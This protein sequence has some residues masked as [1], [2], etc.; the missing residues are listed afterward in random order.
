MNWKL[1]E[2]TVESATLALLE[3][4]GWAVKLGSVIAP[5]ML[6]ATHD[7]YRVMVPR[8]RFHNV[9]SLKFINGKVRA[10]DAEN[11]LKDCRV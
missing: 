5:G 11:I 8:Q 4:L 3:N 6:S 2:S 1:T 7:G 9:L 10:K